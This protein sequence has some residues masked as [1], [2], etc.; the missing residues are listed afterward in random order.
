LVVPVLFLAGRV[1]ASVAEVGWPAIGGPV[2]LGAIAV[3]AALLSRR[4]NRSLDPGRWAMG[5]WVGVG[6]VLFLLGAAHELTVWTGQACFA[7]AAV[8]LWINTPAAEPSRSNGTST[9]PA[10]HAGWGMFIV[11]LLSAAQ[12]FVLSRL[13]REATSIGVAIALAFSGIGVAA[14]AVAA[15]PAW[16]V[17]VGGWSASLGVL[18]AIGL[19]SLLH[20]LPQSVAMFVDPLHR[21]AMGAASV[22]TEVAY[23]FGHFALEA[24]ILIALPLAIPILARLEGSAE[25]IAGGVLLIAAAAVTAGRVAL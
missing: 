18:L 2:M 17:R 19:L 4:N 3:A 7:L 5:C 23:G 8:M 10:R 12:G 13:P 14:S 6:L 24:I 11:L 25:R 15:G 9:T 20:L 22:S 16:A 21:S 1:E